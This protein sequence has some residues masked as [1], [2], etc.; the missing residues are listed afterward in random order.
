MLENVP[1]IQFT[2]QLFQKHIYNFNKSILA[3]RHLTNVHLQLQ[4]EL[5]HQPNVQILMLLLVFVNI[6]QLPNNAKRL[7]HVQRLLLN[8][9]AYNLAVLAFGNNQQDQKQQVLVQI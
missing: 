4:Q 1:V 2:V 5:P 3:Q 9:Y 6:T 7:L 8:K